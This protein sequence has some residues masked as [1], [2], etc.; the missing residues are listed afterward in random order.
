MIKY[1]AATDTL[2]LRSKVL[3]KDAPLE[4]C[5]FPADEVKGGFH[6]GYFAGTSLVCIAT[7]YP[8]DCAEQGIGG[9]RLRGMATDPAFMGKGYGAELIKFA[10]NKLRSVNASYIWCDARSLAVGFYKKLG[11]EFISEEFE[12]TGIGPHFK[13]I[14]IIQ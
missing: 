7:F 13:M 2:P 10:I 12:V 11:F 9:F 4:Q 3:R 5:V 1:I 8:E 6:L 14:K